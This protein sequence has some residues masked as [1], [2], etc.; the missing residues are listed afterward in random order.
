MRSPRRD[1][2][3]PRKTWAGLLVLVPILVW[4]INVIVTEAVGMAAMESLVNGT[5]GLFGLEKSRM[6][7]A[8]AP[9]VAPSIIAVLC[10]FAA[11]KLGEY[12][13]TSFEP[14]PDID[15]RLAFQRV[16]RNRKWLKKN[17]ESDAER[18]KHLRPDYLEI[19]LDEQMHAALAQNKVFAWGQKSQP[20]TDGPF[21]RIPASKWH[22]IE[23]SFLPLDEQTRPYAIRRRADT[24][25]A[26]T[27]AYVGLKLNAAQVAKEFSLSRRVFR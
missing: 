9:F 3:M 5:L 2:F 6:S 10:L 17:T 7:A 24:T 15:P 26:Q 4:A 16:V 19:R 12:E 1:F 22:E 27:I 23:I 8:I 11:F 20:V 14:M 21:D 13:R 25:I 18:R